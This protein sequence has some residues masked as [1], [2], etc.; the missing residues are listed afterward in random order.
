MTEAWHLPPPAYSGQRIGLFGGSFDPPH[1]GHLLVATEALRRLGLDTVWIM[2]SPGN[3][4]KDRSGLPAPDRR[5]AIARR[6]FDHPRMQVT[7]FEAAH[8]FRYSYQTLAYLTSAHPRSRFVFI[9]GADN[10][11]DLHRWQ[12]WRELVRLA[13]FAVYARPGAEHTALASPAAVALARY[14][15]DEAEAQTLANAS[16]PAWVY[17]HGRLSGLSSTALRRN[18]ASP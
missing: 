4:L 17:L 12:R 3:P 7:R 8:G 16:P 14:R 5:V 13:P 18:T 1:A 2:V 6:V 9:M 10:L 11:R 15:L